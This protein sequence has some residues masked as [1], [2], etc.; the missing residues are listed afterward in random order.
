MG[1]PRHAGRNPL[2]SP[3]RLSLHV[4]LRLIGYPLLLGQVVFIAPHISEHAFKGEHLRPVIIRQRIPRR[5]RY[6]PRL[7]CFQLGKAGGG[8]PLTSLFP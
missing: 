7:G 2:V 6:P 4:P 3:S 8:K 1:Y 5:R